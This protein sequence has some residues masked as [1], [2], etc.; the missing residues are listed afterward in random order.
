MTAVSGYVPLPD[1]LEPA[2]Y[3]SEPGERAMFEMFVEGAD[4]G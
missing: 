2:P 1:N 3:N 4:Y